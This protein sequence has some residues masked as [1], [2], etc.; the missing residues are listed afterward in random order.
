LSLLELLKLAVQEKADELLLASGQVPAVRTAQGLRLLE[1]ARLSEK[2][3]SAHLREAQGWQMPTLDADTD[4]WQGLLGVPGVG[5]CSLTWQRQGGQQLA[6]W[7]IL[8]TRLEQPLERW[9][10]PSVIAEIGQLSHGFVLMSGPRR[11]GLST[12]L[13]CLLEHLRHR[14]RVVTSLESP[15]EFL[16]GHGPSLVCQREWPSDFQD[17]HQAVQQAIEVSDT[18]LLPLGDAR[19]ARLAVEAAESGLLVVAHLPATHGLNS[20]DRLTTLLEQPIWIRRLVEVLRGCYSQ[21]LVP[22]KEGLLPVSE[23]MPAEVCRQALWTQEE[24][25]YPYWLDGR[26]GTWSLMVSL[27]EWLDQGKIEE[28]L[29]EN[30]AQSWL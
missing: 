20:L 28:D 30:W 13:A 18:L 24:R 26:E 14:G 21:R 16:L 11:S 7:K 12:T 15:I 8:Q 5:R 6:C 2:D 9:N 27:Q 29:A 17:W 19:L 1:Q 25:P 22:G 3:L 23:F 4:G 10:L